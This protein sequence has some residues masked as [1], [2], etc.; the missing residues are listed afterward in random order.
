[1]NRPNF[2]LFL[3]HLCT[4]VLSVTV[5]VTTIYADTP[6]P[7]TPILASTQPA[8]ISAKKQA[9]IIIYSAAG[10]GPCKSAK[11]LFDEK[12]ISYKVIDIQWKKD[13]IDEMEKLT[14]KR[15]V[16]QIL[17]NGKHVGGY[18]SLI[19]M[20]LTGEL[21]SLI[22]QSPEIKNTEHILTEKIQATP[23]NTAK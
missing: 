4:S 3:K 12:G 22:S 14:G 9:E 19:G 1:M 8:P 17:I 5:V 2:P 18:M 20:D 15:S 21:D 10:C 6:P 11:K 16:P 13:L 23:I 7:S